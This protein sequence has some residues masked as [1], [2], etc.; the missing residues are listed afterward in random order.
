M[1]EKLVRDKHPGLLQK[2][3]NYGQKSFTTLAPAAWFVA[4]T[5]I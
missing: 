1:Q 4:I 5:L 3:V 2:C